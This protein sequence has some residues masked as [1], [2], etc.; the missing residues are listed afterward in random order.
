MKDGARLRIAFATAVAMLAFAGNSLLC[1]LA[2]GSGEMDP[3]SFTAVRI[4]SGAL[5]L[6]LFVAMRGS[7]HAWHQGNWPSAFALW[8]YAAA[9]SVAYVELSA[10]T[11]ALLLF[12][13]VQTTMFG[14]AM[15]HGERMSK[16]QWLGVAIAAA[17]LLMLL[18]PGASAPTRTGGGAMLAA[19]VAWG[20]Y[21]LRGRGAADPTGETAG[22]FIRAAPL[23]L[24]ALWWAAPSWNMPASALTAAVASGA[25]TSGAGYALWYATVRHLRATHAA[26]AQL[27]VPALAAL[28]GVAFL[29]ERLTWQLAVSCFTV[30]AGVAL[31]L[32]RPL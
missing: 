21:S 12:G 11:G 17:G 27:S 19:G 26:V 5:A 24:L 16:L 6:G 30:L 22:N 25:I 7:G 32:R 2:L 1:R 8:I 15:A 10:G 31:A 13:A 28:G 29:A 18:L 4:V 9:F 14:W 23:A 20:V 3:A